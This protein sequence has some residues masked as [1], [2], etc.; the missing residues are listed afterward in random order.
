[1]IYMPTILITGAASGIGA[2]TARRLAAPGAQLLLHT[3]SNMEALRGIANEVRS[4]GAEVAAEIG[5]LAV[6]STA[7]MLV[8]AAKERFGKLDQIVSNAGKAQQSSFECLSEE[9][10]QRAFSIMPIA[11]FS[12]IKAALPLL[13]RSNQARVVAVSSFVAHG[14]GT[15]GLHFPGTSAAKA[16]LEALAKS[17]ASQIAPDG[18]TVNCVAPG[19]VRKDA[20]AHNA[21]SAG[22]MERAREITP[23]RRLGEPDDIADLIA[24]LL[25][26]PA[27]HITGQTIHVDGG[28]LLP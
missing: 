20:T 6:P 22:A 16:A 17:V 8:H 4:K 15:N 13:R 5:D 27:K 14:F 24:Y 9:D 1:M 28:L 7:D 21:T 2:A 12:L 19:F 18:I 11:F 23:N 3:G 10:L 25:S 26:P